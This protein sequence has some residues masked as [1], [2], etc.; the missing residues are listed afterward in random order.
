MG[1][2]DWDS[3]MDSLYHCM[4]RETWRVEKGGPYAYYP[5]ICDHYYTD[6]NLSRKTWREYDAFERGLLSDCAWRR[7]LV[8]FMRASVPGLAAWIPSD[9]LSNPYRKFEVLRRMSSTVIDIGNQFYQDHHELYMVMREEPAY[10]AVWRLLGLSTAHYR[11]ALESPE[12]LEAFRRT[13]TVNDYIQWNMKFDIVGLVEEMVAV[14]GIVNA[15]NRGVL[16]SD[17]VFMNRFMVLAVKDVLDALTQ[18]LKS[19]SC[20]KDCS[21][22]E[23]V[24]AR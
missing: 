4:A 16:M 10:Q 23:A 21:Y 13:Y 24:L 20:L 6:K 9:F 18:I 11:E 12:S 17:D 19:V 3:T 15:S 14:S 5:N 2:D 7:I 1:V 8:D 22:I